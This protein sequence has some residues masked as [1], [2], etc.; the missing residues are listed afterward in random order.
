MTLFNVGWRQEVHIQRPKSR[1]NIPMDRQ[2]PNGDLTDFLEMEAAL[3][4][5]EKS[6]NGSVAKGWLSILCCWEAAV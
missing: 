3:G 5:K 1:S 4:L 2:L 6:Q